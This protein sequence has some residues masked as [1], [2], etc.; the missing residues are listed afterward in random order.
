MNGIPIAGEWGPFDV[1]AC[2]THGVK[3]VVLPDD[4]APADGDGRN[5]NDLHA[6]MNIKVDVLMVGV[7]RDGSRPFW[8]PNDN[9]C[10]R[11]TL[12]APFLG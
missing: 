3:L 8:I 9:V 4:R 2:T 6:F 12:N 1:L 10:I 7:R 11:P 5:A